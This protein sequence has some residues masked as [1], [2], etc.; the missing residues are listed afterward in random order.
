MSTLQEVR[1]Q[2]RTQLDLD[3]DDLSDTTADLFIR[4]GF[5]RTMALEA[6][7]PFFEESWDLTLTSPATTLT[8]PS[9][10]AVIQR[11]RDT[12]ENVNL[13]MIAQQFAEANFQGVQST[14]STPTLFSVWGSVIDLWPTPSA[15]DRTYT[16]RGYR[17][18]T[19]TGTPGEELDGDERLHTAIFHYAC[20]LAYAQMEDPELEAVY[21][22][23]WGALVEAIRRDLMRPQHQEPA[24]LNG[25]LLPYQRLRSERLVLEA[26]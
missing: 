4:E 17:K 6:R 18:P 15:A 10:V 20:S 14:V 9:D 26:P 5:D 24:I 21:M 1:D 13:V 3:T 2:V 11:L 12:G 25:G 8:L 23:R 19:W 7:W 16:L 22:Q